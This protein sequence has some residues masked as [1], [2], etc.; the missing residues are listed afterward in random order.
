MEKLH[1]DWQFKTFE[2]LSQKE[3]YAIL[4]AR[5]EVFIIEQKIYY[6]DCDNRD[7]NA[8]HLFGLDPDGEVVA[9]LR[10]LPPGKMEMHSVGRVLSAKKYRLFGY[11]KELMKNMHEK[12]QEEFGHIPLGMSAQVYLENFYQGFGFKTSSEPYIEEDIEH[13]KMIYQPSN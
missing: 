10:V 8:W 5:Q 11:G 12:V 6:V 4:L 13:I 2:N 1:I 3:L 9:Y 7:Q